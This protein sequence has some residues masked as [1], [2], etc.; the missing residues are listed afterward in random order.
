MRWQLNTTHPVLAA[1][2]ADMLLAEMEHHAETTPQSAA[3]DV[4]IAYSEED[5]RNAKKVSIIAKEADAAAEAVRKQLPA[6]QKQMKAA[7]EAAVLSA[8]VMG[9][10]ST[11]FH[12]TISGHHDPDYSDGITERINVCVDVAQPPEG[13]G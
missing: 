13:E 3:R 9:T 8:K 1:K 7:I 2:L 12:C 6:V 10:A 11:L 5:R 4:T